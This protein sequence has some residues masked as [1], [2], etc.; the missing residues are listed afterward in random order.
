MIWLLNIYPEHV[1][2]PLILVGRDGL[3]LSEL[4]SSSPLIPLTR[5]EHMLWFA[6]FSF[7]CDLVYMPQISLSSSV[8]LLSFLSEDK[9]KLV[10]SA[11]LHFSVGRVSI[12]SITEWATRTYP[13]VWSMTLDSHT[14]KSERNRQKTANSRRFVS[15]RTWQECKQHF[16]NCF[17]F[18]FFFF[19][20]FCFY[21]SF[22]NENFC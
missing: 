9:A 11:W 19:F 2:D 8:F 7:H 12:S 14:G 13:E 15:Q 1:W 16:L 10:L 6:V 22:S 20:F 18:W 5:S 17:V 21:S 3:R 4:C